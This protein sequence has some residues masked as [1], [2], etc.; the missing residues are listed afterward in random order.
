MFHFINI[1]Y[2]IC[3]YIF[4][5]FTPLSYGNY[6]HIASVSRK[7][8]STQFWLKCTKSTWDHGKT[9]S[10]YH[11]R[12]TE[13]SKFNMGIAGFIYVGAN[14]ERS[15][16]N[17]TCRRSWHCSVKIV[18]T[19][20]FVYAMECSGGNWGRNQCM[21]L[22]LHQT[23]NFVIAGTDVCMRDTLPCLQ[24]PIRVFVMLSM[25]SG[26]IYL[27]L[28]RHLVVV[29]R[30]SERILLSSMRSVFDVLSLRPSAVCWQG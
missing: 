4:V 22:H 11:C 19:G 17:V 3:T 25:N 28:K 12:M 7:Y 20:P 21:S 29:H 15:R 5:Q 30:H 16:Y 14:F 2:I 24:S 9:S 10:V 18:F 27:R 13:R 1:S 23:P 6:Q 8:T 26:A